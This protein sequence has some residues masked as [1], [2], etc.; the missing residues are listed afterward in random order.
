MLD[1]PLALE[2][3]LAEALTRRTA[4][5]ERSLIDSRGHYLAQAI[6]AQHDM[7]QFDNSAMDGYALCLHDSEEQL[8]YRLIGRIAAGDSAEPIQ[9]KL[10]QAARILLARRFRMVVMR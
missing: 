4:V 6:S 10:G 3:L 7:P 1:Y 9:L 8:S 2:Q 5:A